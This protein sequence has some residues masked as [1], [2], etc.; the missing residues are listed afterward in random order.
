MERYCVKTIKEYK[1]LMSKLECEGKLWLNGEK[2]TKFTPRNKHIPEE[3]TIYV[4]KDIVWSPDL[5]MNI[6]D[7]YTKPSYYHRG[8][9]D[10][11]KFGEENFNQDEL[12]GFYRMN[13]LKYVTRFDKKGSALPDLEKASYYLEKLKEVAKEENLNG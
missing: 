2:P 3:T 9:I 11:I 4:N 13:V 10:V 5:P 12:K 6:N 7:D 1:K 8:N